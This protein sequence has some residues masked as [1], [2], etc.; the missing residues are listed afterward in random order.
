MTWPSRFAALSIPVLLIVSAVSTATWF[1]SVETPPWHTLPPPPIQ[2][3]ES[4]VPA[5]SEE[6]EPFTFVSYNVRNWLVS[7]RSPEKTRES[8]DAVIRL[9]T[10]SGAD[11]IGLSEIGSPQ[12]VAEI[13]SLLKAAGNDLPY[14]HHGGGA[15]PVR[16]LALLSRFPIVSTASPELVI[17]GTDHSMRRGILDTTILAGKR[18]VRLIGLHLKSKRSVPQ[19]DQALVRLEEAG[20]ARAHLNA[21]FE[22]DTNVMLVAYGDWND[23][24]RS[25]STRTILGTFR[26]P[27]YLTLVNVKDSRGETWTHFYPLQDVYSRID[28]VATSAALRRH[29]DRKESRIMDDPQWELASDHRPVVVRFRR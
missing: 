23:T 4:L 15:D 2:A 8:K 18:P 14:S 13:Q 12:D 19:F 16:H 3:G 10:D 27:A 17:A 1:R 25:L 5:L 6:L 9:L 24:S 26:S 29:V 21:I 28:F 7:S 11:V 20:H 22:K